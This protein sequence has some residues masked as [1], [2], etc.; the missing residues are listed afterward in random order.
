MVWRCLIRGV[1][2]RESR[3]ADVGVSGSVKWYMWECNVGVW[4]G[5]GIWCIRER[6]GRNVWGWGNNGG[7]AMRWKRVEWRR[8]EDR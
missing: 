5:G 4:C 7:V 1:R 2:V 3:E 8:W 6:W